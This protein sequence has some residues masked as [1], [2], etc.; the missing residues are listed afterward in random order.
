MA[1]ETDAYGLHSS[2]G[3]WVNRLAHSMDEVFQARLSEHGI[4]RGLWPILAALHRGDAST[5]AEVARFVGLD[6]S[7]VTRLLDRL[8]EKGL[9]ARRPNGSDRRSVMLE[10]TAEGKE[11]FPKLAA[12]SKETKEKF[13]Q[14][15]TQED[16]A[17]LLRIIKKMLDNADG[18]VKEL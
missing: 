13:L 4:T 5:P 17:T 11:L 8:E 6:A 14:G 15:V 18:P 7:A 10:L 9:L 1:N 2:T 16:A 3:Y 12:C